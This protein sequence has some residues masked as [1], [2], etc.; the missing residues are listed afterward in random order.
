MISSSRSLAISASLLM[1]AIVALLV[2]AQIPLDPGMTQTF[3]F[4]GGLMSMAFLS[5]LSNLSVRAEP[6]LELEFSPKLARIAIDEAIPAEFEEVREE[7]PWELSAEAFMAEDP[8][9]AL[10]K[11]RIDIEREVRRIASEA[12]MRPDR[13]LHAML[14]ALAKEEVLPASLHQVLR[15][16]LPP[17]NQAVH[18]LKVD[19]EQAR[20]VLDLGADLVRYL[21]RVDGREL[22]ARRAAQSGEPSA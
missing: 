6:H 20:D 13:S 12:A 1:L 18:G 17:L 16:V 11:T 19:R 15:D 4:I 22:R 2:A 3:V 7:R 21:S 10:A 8:T 14:Q 5:S 9:L